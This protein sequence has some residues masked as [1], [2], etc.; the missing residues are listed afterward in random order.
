M[1]PAVLSSMIGFAE[2]TSG[3][4]KWT[5]LT[6]DAFFTGWQNGGGTE[7]VNQGSTIYLPQ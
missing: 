2:L 5:G 6:G 4:G 1:G 7:T 3:T